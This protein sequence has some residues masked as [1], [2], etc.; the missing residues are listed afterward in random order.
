MVPGAF[1]YHRPNT[2]DGVIGL[3]GEWGDDARVIA[4]GHSLIPVMK[5]RLSDISHLIDLAGVDSLKGVSVDGGTVTIGAIF[6]VGAASVGW[7]QV[8][9][10]VGTPAIVV[11]PTGLLQPHVKVSG[12]ER[13]A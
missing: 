8:T 9:V 5:Q 7:A 4:G 2:V 11:R 12:T 3:L 10:V 6:S 13:S 1:N